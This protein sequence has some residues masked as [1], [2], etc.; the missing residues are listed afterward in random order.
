MPCTTKDISVLRLRSIT[1]ELVCKQEFHCKFV[2]M[3][4]IIYAGRHFLGAIPD[5]DSLS[6]TAP[7]E[8]GSVAEGINGTISAD[9]TRNT[10]VQLD[11]M[12]SI[13]GN[14]SRMLCLL[15]DHA[16]ILKA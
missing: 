4:V 12:S 10:P 13:V 1:D 7:L 11:D 2:C 15:F 14:P 16:S 9:C 8:S 6:L 5:S 3:N